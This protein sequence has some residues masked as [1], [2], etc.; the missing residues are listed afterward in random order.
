MNEAPERIWLETRSFISSRWSLAKDV[1][2]V[3]ADLIP[4]ELNYI[5][6]IEDRDK[7]IEELE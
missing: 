5:P 1:E 7:R 6:A 2:Y 4:P 3:R